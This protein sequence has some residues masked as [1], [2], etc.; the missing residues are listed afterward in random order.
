MPRLFIH[1]ANNEGMELLDLS[2]NHIRMKG[3]VA[4]CAGLRVGSAW[5]MCFIFI[6]INSN[7]F[8]LR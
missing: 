1:T 6:F 3:A 2:W 7:C 4:F 5:E 8:H